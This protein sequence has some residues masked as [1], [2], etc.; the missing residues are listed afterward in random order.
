MNFARW[1]FR[2]AGVYG[3]LV[4]LPQ[5]F[6]EG[7]I[8]RDY[9]PPITHP[10]QFY[11]FVGV[12][13]AWQVAF[14]VIAQDPARYRTMMLPAVL[15]KATFGVAVLVLFLQQRVA[16]VFVGFAAV[17]LVLGVLFLTAWWRCRLRGWEGPG[18]AGSNGSPPR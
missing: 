2:I 17:D 9:P 18:G 14:L 16:A 12:V 11:G 13:V 3:L 15:E 5:Y 6:L 7:Q 8:G 10:E 4:M 1:V